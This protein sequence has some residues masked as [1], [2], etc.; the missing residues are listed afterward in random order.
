MISRCHLLPS[1]PLI[2]D[3]GVN[4]ARSR[5]IRDMIS[6]NICR[7]ISTSVIE[8]RLR[9][10]GSKECVHLQQAVYRYRAM[11]AGR[12]YPAERSDTSHL[13]RGFTRGVGGQN[14]FAG[15]IGNIGVAPDLPG[16]VYE[17]FLDGLHQQRFV[18]ALPAMDWNRE[19][20]PE[21]GEAGGY[22]HTGPKIKRRNPRIAFGDGKPDPGLDI[23]VWA[24][25]IKDPMSVP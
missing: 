7:G 6:A 16:A 1:I 25:G 3:L 18:Q 10:D 11:K 24:N 23:I 19:G 9:P 5:A 14:D 21:E 17:A 2:P 4:G 8:S 13:Y 12:G 20:V 22:L 15:C